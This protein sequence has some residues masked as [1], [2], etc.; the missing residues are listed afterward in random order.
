VAFIVSIEKKVMGMIDPT[1]FVFEVQESL[2]WITVT[3]PPTSFIQ[4]FTVPKQTGVFASFDHVLDDPDA[5]ITIKEFSRRAEEAARSKAREL[6][7]IK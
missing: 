2:R 6:D 1:D 5:D 4:T 3:L 7:W